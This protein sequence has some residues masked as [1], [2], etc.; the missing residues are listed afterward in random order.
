MCT[1]TYIPSQSKNFILTSS[2]DEHIARPALPVT[3]YSIHGKEVYFPKDSQAGG[4]WIAHAQK[5]FTICLLNGAF[6]PHVREASYRLSRGIALLDFFGFE[7]PQEYFSHYS[8]SAIEPFTLVIID[9]RKSSNALW[10]FRW[11]GV[12]GHVRSVDAAIPH[13][14]SS[15]TLYPA[16]IRKR[17]EQLFKE[18][19]ESRNEITRDN[20]IHFH[21][22]GGEHNK[23]LELMI[24][25][26]ERKTVS[27]CSVDYSPE[28]TEILYNDLIRKEEHKKL[29][30][31]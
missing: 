25:R 23:D 1:V 2:R 22:T 6:E 8:F 28:Q 29:I 5:G 26:G 30:T 17:R 14:W 18:W 9:H 24:D 16:E 13:I 21:R 20:V 3:N 27:I 19:V 15:V 4:T 10:E 11:D 7:S 12:H 31:V